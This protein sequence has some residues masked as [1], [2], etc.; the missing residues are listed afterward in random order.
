MQI[1]Y[2]AIA[3]GIVALAT[4]GCNS[5]QNKEGQQAQTSPESSSEEVFEAQLQPLNAV[6]TGQMT[7]GEARFVIS[8]DTMTVTIDVKN[9]PKGIQHWQ[10]FHGFASDSVAT[11]AT[12][13]EDKN[14]DGII[15][16][17]ETGPVSGTTMVPFN[18]MPAKMDVGNSSYPV[19]G[20]DGSYHYESKIPMDSLKAAF[21]RA[22]GGSALDLDR[23]V[24]Y[25]HGVPADAKLPKSVASI[26]DIPASI[27]LPI[28]C[29]Q[30]KKVN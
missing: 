2:L 21:S 20:E 26:A 6:V 18:A 7:T 30:I 1:N 10:H 11:C 22:F 14:G 28:A 12:N 9:A 19:A 29:G 13:A 4:V 23:R 27:T 25:I 3:V 5:S 16:V 24:L 15:D 17:V 8:G